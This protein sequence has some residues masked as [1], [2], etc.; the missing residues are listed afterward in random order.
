[1]TSGAFPFFITFTFY[2]AFKKVYF[3]SDGDSGRASASTPSPTRFSIDEAATP[4]NAMQNAVEK[5]MQWCRRWYD[6]LLIF[7]L[8]VLHR[9]QKSLEKVSFHNFASE[10]SYLYILDKSSLKMVNLASFWKTEACGQ[11]VLP[12]ILV[13]TRQK[14]VENAKIQLE[15]FE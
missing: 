15:H 7:V 10:A 4:H 12:D 2:S 1:M 14:L 3:S 13:L 9:G 11:T 6:S 5:E 8:L